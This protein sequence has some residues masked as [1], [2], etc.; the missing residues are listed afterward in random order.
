MKYHP[1]CKFINQYMQ[2]PCGSP[3]FKNLDD[4]FCL[5]HGTAYYDIPAEELKVFRDWLSTRCV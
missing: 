1:K 2:E 4:W 5:Y 3:L